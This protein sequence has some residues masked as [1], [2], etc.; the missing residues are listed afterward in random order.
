MKLPP[1]W[2]SFTDPSTGHLC[3]CNDLSGETQWEPPAG[4]VEMAAVENP[5]RKS[6]RN[7]REKHKR[8]STK[9]PAGWQKHLD[10]D[11]E[12]YYSHN[13]GTTSDRRR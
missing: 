7:K 10:D 2:S 11:G 4:S 3:Y 9:M 8:N 12:R 5:M 6:K 1:G 13:D